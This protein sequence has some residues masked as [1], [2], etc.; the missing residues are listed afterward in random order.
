[1][2][3][4]RTAPQLDRPGIRVPPP[5]VYL[6]TTLVGIAIDL[7][8]PVRILPDAVAGWL[9]GAL[10][11]L[12]LTVGGISVQEFGKARTTIH[13]NR[14]PSALV[15]TGPFRYSRNPMYLGLSVVQVGIGVWLNRAWVIVLVIPALVWI[16][17][18]VIPREERRLTERFGPAYL[19]YQ[20]RV[21]RW[22]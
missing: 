4:E 5:L 7:I 3:S 6:A 1:M 9:G 10:V 12:G 20:A 16:R 19:D 17:H 8:V 15:T 22:L 11:V 14:P 21:R 13:P 2:R 18:R